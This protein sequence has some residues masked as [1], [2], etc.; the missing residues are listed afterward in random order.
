MII[1]VTEFM[2]PQPYEIDISDI[3][4][5]KISI[6]PSVC[7]TP[8]A[9]N[10]PKKPVSVRRTKNPVISKLTE[11]NMNWRDD[12]S[13]DEDDDSSSLP[14]TSSNRKFKSCI[15]LV[16]KK[17]LEEDLADEVAKLNC[18]TLKTSTEKAGTS[19]TNVSKTLQTKNSKLLSNNED[20]GR[21]ITRSSVRRNQKEKPS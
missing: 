13:D 19:L 14:A 7:V 21:R 6:D 9:Q 1:S 11:V 18:K 3:S 5:T 20:C 16:K 4:H 8:S 10:R 15:N 17:I 12:W 2:V